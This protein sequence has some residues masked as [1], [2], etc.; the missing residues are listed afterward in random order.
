[1]Q[2]G[3][4][5]GFHR[6]IRY[7]YV[8][9]V[10]AV[11]CFEFWNALQ[12]DGVNDYIQT[13][14]TANLT[15]TIGLSFW[16]KS[17]AG[18]GSVPFANNGTEYIQNQPGLNRIVGYIDSVAVWTHTYTQ[19]PDVWQHFLLTYIGTEARVYING[20]ESSTGARANTAGRTFS[21]NRV[22]SWTG[23][24]GASVMTIDELAATTNSSGLTEAVALYNNGNGNDANYVFG[25]TELYYHLDES[26][27]DT[28]VLDASGNGNDGT[29]INFDESGMWVGYYPGIAMKDSMVASWSFDT[30]FNDSI[31]TNHLTAN[32]NA[33]AGAAC[34]VIGKCAQLDGSSD[35]GIAVDSDTLSFTN[36]TNDLP[37]SV[38]FW[39]KFN[40]YNFSGLGGVWM[41]SKREKSNEDEYQ[42]MFLESAIY[43]YLFSGDPGDNIYSS[44]VFVPQVGNDAVWD[45]F[46]F[47]YDGSETA[48]GI[49]IYLNGVAQAMTIGSTGAYT[50]MQNLTS[51]VNIGSAGFSPTS[52]G[53]DG[54]LDLFHIWKNREISATEALSIYDIQNGGGSIF[55]ESTAIPFAFG[56]VLRSDGVNDYVSIGGGSLV[57]TGIPFSISFWAKPNSYGSQIPIT[58]KGSNDLFKIFFGSYANGWSI[59]WGSSGALGK[60]KCNTG[61]ISGSWAHIAITYDG[62]TSTSSLSYVMKINNVLQTLS[63][64]SP[65]TSSSS[66][67]PTQLFAGLHG[68]ANL[69]YYD[70]DLDEI[71]FWGNHQFTSA[72]I[73]DLY[74]SGDGDYASDVIASPDRYYRLNET[75]TDTTATDDGS[76]AENGTLSN[77]T[78]PGAWVPRTPFPF[79]NALNADGVNDFVTLSSFQSM[80]TTATLSIWFYMNDTNMDG[81]IIGDSTSANFA[82]RVL[83]STSIRLF[84]GSASD[85]TVQ[86]MSSENWYNLV[87]SITPSGTRLYLN[88][89]ESSSGLQANRL[90]AFNQL[91]KYYTTSGAFSFNGRFDEFGILNGTSPTTQNITD[92]YNGGYG[93]DFAQVMGNA[94]L[95]LKFNESDTAT[96]AVDSSGNGNDGTLINFDTYGMWVDHY[97]GNVPIHL[98]AQAVI[99]QM[100]T[101]GSTPIAGRQVIINQLVL[102]LKG[103]GNTGVANVWGNLDVLQIYAAEDAIQGLTE[104]RNADGSL[105]ATEVNSPVFTVDSGFKGS[106]LARIRSGFIASVNGSSYTLNNASM[107]VYSIP[108]TSAY[109][110]GVNA[111]YRSW[112]RSGTGVSNQALNSSGFSS[113]N[114]G[115]NA[116]SEALYIV[117]RDSST[118]ISLILNDA[119]IASPVLSTSSLSPIAAVMPGLATSATTF[120]NGTS[121]ITRIFFSGGSIKANRTQLYDSFQAYL[122]SVDPDPQAFITAALITGS[123][124]QN[125]IANLVSDLKGTSGSTTNGTDVWSKLRAF[126]PMCPI[127]ATTFTLDACKWNLINPLDTDAAF[128][129]TWV[130]SPTVTYEGVKGDGTSAYGNTH[131]VESAQMTAGNNG[132]TRDSFDIVS[133]TAQIIAGADYPDF[134]FRR[135]NASYSGRLGIVHTAAPEICTI[136]RLTPTDFTVYKDGTSV[137]TLATSSTTQANQP[138]FVFAASDSSGNPTIPMASG[139]TA[140][141]IHDGLTANEAQDISDAI[142]N[143]NTAL[144][145]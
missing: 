89:V 108:A 75:G 72:E 69:F 81:T 141:A 16:V 142:T 110:A 62:G 31:G 104:W 137:A 145:R 97:T 143:F 138:M 63:S 133:G 122:T 66:A 46:Q 74:N 126:Y 34:G 77:F 3:Y 91:F 14:S 109:L 113:T 59:E 82:Y 26:G 27:T 88:D 136:S 53:F 50:G 2:N 124:Q 101:N 49:Q 99:N 8:G 44:C 18:I 103:I 57:T 22:G 71:A 83:S 5:Y 78:L 92:L 112:I 7:T 23:S 9:P 134:A 114:F 80:Q 17:A 60:F 30:N 93:A 68:G 4:G 85:Y 43:V 58:L 84:A 102:D 56:N 116:N 52:R 123:T 10:P 118:N 25:S 45:N 33:V 13:T 36:G 70:G 19:T 48:D 115:V 86:T 64:T 79:G 51:S 67:D 130:N 35:Y 144:G 37:F 6:L 119:I 39:A 15:G 127:D 94:D 24:S 131:F 29:L 32:G 140:F 41:L 95:H 117:D 111:G 55:L 139:L 90:S 132:M 98:D 65:I 1:M 38:S 21:I 20:V 106:S 100:T 54:E 128:R 120:A 121:T 28:I 73:T 47:T 42:I 76:D 11:I 105:D 87:L 40:T 129:M 125:S 135:S 96:T 61:D 12:F 107:G